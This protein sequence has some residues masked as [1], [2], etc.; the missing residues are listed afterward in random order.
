MANERAA[1]IVEYII[2]LALI[3]LALVA[4]IPALWVAISGSY[5]GQINSFDTSNMQP[6]YTN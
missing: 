6:L 2:T 1:T 5:S 4:V 3:V